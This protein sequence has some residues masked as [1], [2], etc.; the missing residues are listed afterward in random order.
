LLL[1]ATPVLSNE[2][3]FLA[4]LHL[5]DPQ[6][7]RLGDL[8]AFRARVEKRQEVGHLLLS[9]QEGSPSFL[10]RSGI[11]Q[12]R[13]HFPAD[14][15]LSQL[16]ADLERALADN[17]LDAAARDR[18]IRAIRVQV[19][20]TYRLHRRMLRNRRGAVQVGTLLGRVVEGEKGT[21]RTL[22]HDL[23]ERS[24]KIHTLI[25]EWR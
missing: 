6:V 18:A 12:L 25:E 16:G 22:E 24:P 8:E 19:S 23:D 4:M 5:L 20:E 14:P 9:L 7:Y 15:P 10:L 1:S 17:P 3:D 13:E 21:P 11:A 2:R